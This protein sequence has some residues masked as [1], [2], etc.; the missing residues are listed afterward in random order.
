[1][2]PKHK[3]HLAA[4]GC[5][6]A[7]ALSLLH[8]GWLAAAAALLLLLARLARTALADSRTDPLTGLGNLRRLEARR[9]RLERHPRLEVLYLDVDDLKRPNDTRGHQAG[10]DALTEV[11]RRLSRAAGSTGEA[12]R[13]GGDEFLLI[14]PAGDDSGLVSR[15]LAASKDLPHPVSWGCAAGT[16]MDELIRRAEADVCARKIRK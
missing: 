7:M 8:L 14:A 12:Y 9:P 11:A 4:A 1:M 6:A 13:I 15:W 5:L 3:I 2:E 16:G 10:S